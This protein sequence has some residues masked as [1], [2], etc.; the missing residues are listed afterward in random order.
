MQRTKMGHVGHKLAL[1]ALLA[2]MGTAALPGV[3]YVDCLPD[4]ID[5]ANDLTEQV[6][7]ADEWRES[8]EQQLDASALRG[9][10]STTLVID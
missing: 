4:A 8:L 3:G 9:V 1:V 7:D 10:A 2:R 6:F 5:H